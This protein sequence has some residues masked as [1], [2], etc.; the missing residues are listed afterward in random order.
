MTAGFRQLALEERMYR[1][2]RKSLGEAF[3]PSKL[4]NLRPEV[5]RGEANVLRIIGQWQKI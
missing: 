5:E 1:F 2:V 3:G 4:D